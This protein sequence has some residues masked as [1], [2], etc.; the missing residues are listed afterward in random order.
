[1]KR[2]FSLIV[3]LVVAL[4]A[5]A[6]GQANG[7][8]D[9]PTL[10]EVDALRTEAL[11]VL[12]A[13]FD[14]PDRDEGDRLSAIF[15]L[16]RVDHPSAISML[17]DVLQNDPFPS[18]RREAARGLGDSQAL[19]ALPALYDAVENEFLNSVRWVAAVSILRL[20]PSETAFLDGLIADVDI[21]AEAALFLENEV[22]A[23]T[24]P[25]N[26]VPRVELAMIAALPDSRS[27]NSV[28]R[29]ALLK[30]LGTLHSFQ[31]VPALL[32]ILNDVDEDTF[33][34]GSSAFAL[35]KL[36]AKEA[37]PD[38]IASLDSESSA[39]QIGALA[40][41]N[42]LQD[43]QSVAT[44]SMLLANDESVE[45]RNNAAQALANY[46]LS[47]VPALELA[48]NNDASPTVRT[49]TMIGLAF[50]G[51]PAAAE[52]IIAFANGGFLVECE[53]AC[54][55]LALETISALAQVG[56]GDMAVEMLS[57][58]LDALAQFIAFF[59][60][61]NEADLVR[62][63]TQLGLVSPQV[64]DLLLNY[65][66]PFIRGVGVAALSNVKGRNGR[67][68]L[69]PF[70]NAD[71]NRVVRRMALEG[72]ALWATAD[73]VDLF[74]EWTIDRDR[75]SRGAAFDALA[76]A[77]DERALTPI[78][79]ALRATSFSN[80]MQATEGAFAYANRIES[81]YEAAGQFI[82]SR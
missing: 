23:E 25:E 10:A 63:A 61:F 38:L 72:L 66:N 29:S 82:R 41:L 79:D 27:Y 21:L 11:E 42:L 1:M 48:L 71:E 14:D 54:A 2:L 35:G 47:A 50:I 60:A 8:E 73:D 81:L 40:A 55:L 70:I 52:A 58:S 3:I 7:L 78:M 46:G 45:V 34:R 5:L 4:P 24:F 59:F 39:V 16:N 64:F 51:G 30:A 20:R 9:F 69:L 65:D 17:I 62:V 67:E 13:V 74:T 68:S 32:E 22:N 26:L 31:A 80:R 53:A 6:W 76:N 77:G 28:E 43:R 36:S 15:A 12:Q 18:V 56:E 19:E 44:I 57:G 49:S 33:V 37:I 75:R